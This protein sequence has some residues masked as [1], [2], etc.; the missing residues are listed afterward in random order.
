MFVT[1][2]V[3]RTDVNLYIALD[4]P[5]TVADYQ[6]RVQEIRTGFQVPASG[7]LDD[8]CFAAACLQ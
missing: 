1:G 6:D 2:P 3:S 4:A 5:L 7:M 8:D